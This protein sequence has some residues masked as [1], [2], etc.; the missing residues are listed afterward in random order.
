MQVTYSIGSLTA[1][2][3]QIYRFLIK[4]IRDADQRDGA[5]FVERY[6][7][8]PQ[9]VWDQTR[10]KILDVQ[11]LWD[12]EAI[13]DQFLPFLKSIVGWTKEPLTA[14]ITNAITLA[15]LRRL[16]AASGAIWR[17]KGPEDTI[18]DVLRTVA[19]ARAR[20][21]NWFDFRWV[22]GQNALG[23]DHLGRDPWVTMLPADGGLDHYRSN[24]RIV[25]DGTLD[26][27]L[28][29]RVLRLMR[30]LNER[31]DITYLLFLDLFEVAGDDVQW[32][33]PSSLN[34]IILVSLLEITD[35]TVSQATFAIVPNAT[36][37]AQYI[38]G[39]RISGHSNV[40]NA[41]FGITFYRTD[42]SNYY[43]A[44]IDTV[45]QELR[46]RT[47]V[48]GV[49][50]DLVT[51]NLNL[52]AVNL[53]ADVYYLLRVY[54]AVEGAT[55]RIIVSVDGAILINTTN[56]SHAA[57]SVGLIHDAAAV[58]QCTETEVQ[59]LPA[60]TDTLEINVTP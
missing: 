35:P 52:A 57:G 38:Y 40:G 56:N 24:L 7:K 55:N 32:D 51:V 33:H 45:N 30:A 22:L 53:L 18:L 39:A 6:L 8:G 1:F 48:A 14:N 9:A 29:R 21:W 20:I 15:T 10:A 59:G 23:E 5:Q 43:A 42:A 49:P 2:P 31:F 28:V 54:I 60:Q 37:W 27:S 34:L 36:T 19:P 11:D 16:I 17:A 58:L 46:L 13:P 25:D 3:L 4:A 26:R 44:L 50:T 41:R 12:V 47:V